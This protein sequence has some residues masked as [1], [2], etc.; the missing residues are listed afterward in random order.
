[1]QRNTNEKEDFRLLLNRN[2]T[3]ISG[4]TVETRRMVCSGITSQMSRRLQEIES[5]FNAHIVEAINCA[6][7]EK[8]LPSIQNTV[9]SQNENSSAKMADRIKIEIVMQWENPT[10]GA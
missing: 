5:D 9:K 3:E 8:V 10:W 6:I 2:L 4:V 7:V 1:M